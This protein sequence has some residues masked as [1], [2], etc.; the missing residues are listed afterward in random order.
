MKKKIANIVCT[1]PPYRGGMGKSAYDFAKILNKHFEVTTLTSSTKQAG[2]EKKDCGEVKR[3]SS[4]IKYGN[5][6]FYP[7]IFFEL[8]NSDYIFLHYPF[9][10]INELVWLYKLINSKKKLVIYY[11]MDTP[12][13]ALIPRLLSF[14]S[15]FIRNSLFKMADTILCSSFDYI[16]NGDIVLQYEKYKDKFKEIPF[17]VDT[18][19][20]YPRRELK[21][22]KNFNILFVGGLDEAHRFKGV[23]ILIKAAAKI[24]EN[25]KVNLVGNGELVE[26]YKKLSKDLSIEKKVN[27]LENIEDDELKKI[28]RNADVFVLPST[29]KNEAFGIVLVEAMAS[30]VPVVASNFP[31]VRSVF[32]D[33]IQGFRIKPNSV[34]DLKEKLEILIKNPGQRNKMALDA[35]RLAKEKYSWDKIEDKII[36]NF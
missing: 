21:N 32:E 23:D 12:K 18:S 33:G 34:N 9:F 36:K 30:G 16:K 26:E 4:P 19:E 28:F 11:H 5:G 7:Q 25:Y 6:G 27:F 31:G 2:E 8:K 1:F 14:H 3:F 20:L 22:E 29:S 13:L 17:G 24:K 15:N 10:G 35:R